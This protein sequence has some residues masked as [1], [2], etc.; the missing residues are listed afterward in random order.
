MKLLSKIL[1]AFLAL[2]LAGLSFAQPATTKFNNFGQAPTWALAAPFT[3]GQCLVYSTAVSAFVNSTCG[4]GGGGTVTSVS[5][6]SANGFGGTVATAT[7]TPAITLTTSI[8]GPL[9]GNGTALQAAAAT[10]ISNTLFGCSSSTTLFL[11]GD[12]TCV[13]PTGTG[14]ALTAPAAFT[15]TGSGTTSIALTYSGTAIPLSS[16]GTNSTNGSILATNVTGYTVA[17]VSGNITSGTTGVGENFT[18]TVNDASAVDG[19]LRKAA[20]TCTLCTATSFI[21]DVLVGAT[22]VYELDT[23]GNLTVS[24]QLTGVGA[25]LTTPAGNPSISANQV[26]LNV[27]PSNSSTLPGTTG[28]LALSATS[29]LVIAGSGSTNDLSLRNKSALTV[30]GIPTNTSH[31]LLAGTFLTATN[32]SACGTTPAINAQ[33]TDAKGTITEGTTATGCVLTFSTAYATTP[34]CIV[35]SPSGILPTSYTAATT[36]LTIVNTSATGDKFTY[37]CIQ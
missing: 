23:A 3:N 31:I 4:A 5:V 35:T 15:V 8:N 26:F 29:G 1:G 2:T 20:I 6:V 9:K 22:H 13:A 21:D 7:T 34:D 33:A 30:L 37:H 25:T 36:T 16:G 11:R 17:N 14:I 12:G 24:G 28:Y 19:I 18:V 32:L 10:D 27:A